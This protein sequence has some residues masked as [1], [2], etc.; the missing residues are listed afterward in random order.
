MTLGEQC[1]I[2]GETDGSDHRITHFSVLG[3]HGRGFSRSTALDFRKAVPKFG[4][5]P[6]EALLNGNC[7]TEKGKIGPLRCR[8]LKSG[9]YPLFFMFHP[10]DARGMG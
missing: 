10:A 2:W 5:I 7:G 9:I 8:E 1:Q 4:R 3:V 6:W